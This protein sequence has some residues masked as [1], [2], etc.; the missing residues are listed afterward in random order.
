M[1]NNFELLFFVWIFD[2]V[3]VIALIGWVDVWI[4][5]LWLLTWVLDL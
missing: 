1:F 2:S 5:D 4:I 3:C